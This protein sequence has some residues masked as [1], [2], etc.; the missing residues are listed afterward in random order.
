MA[1]PKK[2]KELFREIFLVNANNLFYVWKNFNII[3][4]KNKNS[5]KKLIPFTQVH[6]LFTFYPI[7]CIICVLCV[8]VA[9]HIFPELLKGKLHILWPITPNTLVCIQYAFPKTKYSLLHSHSIVISVN[10]TAILFIKSTTNPIFS[11]DPIISF[12]AYVLFPV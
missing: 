3:D 12:R 11:F 8:C 7:C 5:M 10:L 1:Q 4:S 9:V 6:L 2:I